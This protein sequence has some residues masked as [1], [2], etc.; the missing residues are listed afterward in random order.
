MFAYI[1]FCG[2][3]QGTRIYDTEAEA[4]TAAASR[5]ALDGRHW[6]VRCI[7][8]PEILTSGIQCYAFVKCTAGPPLNKRL[9]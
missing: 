3:A 6:Q 2:S 1:I 8:I 4:L 9:T 5:S 7:W